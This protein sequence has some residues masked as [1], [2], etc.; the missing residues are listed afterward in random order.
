M[1]ITISNFFFR[2]LGGLDR[3]LVRK[4]HVYF[5]FPEHLSIVNL[6]YVM[7]VIRNALNNKKQYSFPSIKKNYCLIMIYYDYNLKFL[8]HLYEAKIIGD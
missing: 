8:I 2:D 3:V 1:L 6:H 4:V 7:N 5:F